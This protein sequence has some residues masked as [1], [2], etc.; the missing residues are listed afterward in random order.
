MAK[1]IIFYIILIFTFSVQSQTY[2]I[3]TGT[4]T[5]GLVPIN[6]GAAYS[7]SQTIYPASLLTAQGMQP[8]MAITSIAWYINTANTSTTNASWVVYLGNTAQTSYTSTTNWIASTSLTQVFTG[9][10]VPSPIGWKTITLASPFIWNG[11][12]LVIAVD[13]SSKIIYNKKHEMDK[14]TG[15]DYVQ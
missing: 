14:L 3:G 13:E 7:Y 11:S 4:S 15:G 1:R 8:G 10:V 12:N 9:S 6:S 2:T 5:T